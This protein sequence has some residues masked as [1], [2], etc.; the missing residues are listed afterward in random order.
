MTTLDDLIEHCNIE[1]LN[2]AYTKWLDGMRECTILSTDKISQLVEHL[3]EGLSL[4]KII[5]DGN[6]W[7]RVVESAATNFARL[8]AA[9]DNKIKVRKSLDHIKKPYNPSKIREKY[10][11]GDYNAELLL[12]HALLNLDGV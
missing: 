11:S 1:N 7:V 9:H 8:E 3:A 12:Q 2:F 10:L 4:E 5:H 6:E